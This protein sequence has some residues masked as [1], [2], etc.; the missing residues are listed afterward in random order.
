MSGALCCDWASRAYR[1]HAATSRV[2]S[3]HLPRL[4]NA[5]ARAKSCARDVVSAP[6]PTHS[7]FHEGARAV[8]RAA[9]WKRTR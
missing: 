8:R 4:A 5:R 7:S 6:M 9:I 1:I 3:R 2:T